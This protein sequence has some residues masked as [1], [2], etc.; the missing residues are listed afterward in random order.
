MWEE[1]VCIFCS[2]GKVE[3]K[4]HFILK[5]EAFKDNRESYADTLTASSSDN[6][7]SERFV[8]KIGAFILKLHTK[9]AKY[10][11]QIKK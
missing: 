7:F 2:C 5:C 3:T 9:K 8:E 6:L 10:I 11:K 1:K 4:K